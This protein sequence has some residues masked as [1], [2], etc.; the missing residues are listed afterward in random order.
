MRRPLTTIALAI[1]ATPATLPPPAIAQT[2]PDTP[3][4]APAA[5]QTATPRFADHLFGSLRYRYAGPSRG[6]RVT[7]VAGHRAH[8]STFYM[9]ATGGGVWKTTDRGHSWRNI[10]DGHFGT[11]SIGAIR[12]AESDFNVVYVS[13][14]SDG[15]RSNVI[16]G[17][18]V[19]KSADAGETWEHMGLERTGN[20]GA[21]LIHPGDPD[22]VYVAAIGSP[23][24]PNPERGVYRSSDGGASWEQVLFVSDSTGAVDLEFAPDDPN[25]VY[26][27]MWRAER[28]PWTIVSGGLEGGVYVSRDGGD[29]WAQATD[30]LPAGLRGKSDLAVSPADPDR[31]YVLIEAPADTGGVYRSDDRGATWHQV[32]D[33]QPIRNRP[34]YYTNL[35]AHPADADILWG[36]AEGHWMSI[37]GGRSWTRRPTPHSDNHDLWINP[38]DPDIMIQSN[39]GGANVTT[40]GGDTWSTQLN[41]PTAELYQ[42]D[43][44][45]GF[46]YRLHAG[47]QDN[48]TVSVPG[49]P[50]RW[51]PGGPRSAWEAHGGCETGPIVPKPGDPDIVYANCKGRFG[52]YNRRTGQEQQYYVG[53]ANLYGHNPRD[54]EYRFQRVA[55]VHVSPHD[56]N[57]V[58][59]GSQFVHV[60]TDGGRRWETISDDLTAFT[61][62]TQVV[63][64]TPI[65]LD[66]TGEEHFAALYEIQESVLEPGVI[67]AGANDGPVHVTRDG[68]AGW[69]DVTPP[70][71]GPHG[72]VQ[73]IEV[74]HHDPAKAYVAIL[75]YQLGDFAP[76]AYRTDD[77]GASWTRMTT[78]N[79]GVPGDHP[80]RVV[81]EDPE[82][83]GLL[84]LGT[85]FGV[86]VSFD[87]GGTWQSFQLNLP[88]TPVTD[89]K[90]VRGDLVLSTMGRGFWI[91][92]NLTPLHELGDSVAGASAH[93]YDVRDAYRLRYRRGFGRRDASRPSYPQAGAN[94]DY[95]LAQVPDVPLALD[96]VDAEGHLVRSFSSEEPGEYVV[97]AEPGMREWRLERVG[98]P[99]LPGGAGTHRFTWDLRH[100]GP[101]N[102]DPDRTGRGGPMVP[103]GRYTA[104]LSAGDW[105]ASRDFRVML[106]P[107]VAAEG[108]DEGLVRRQVGFALEVRDALSEAR[109]AAHR[110]AEARERGGGELAAEVEAVERELVTEPRRYSRPMLVDQLRY[111]Y[112]NLTRADQE[113]GEDAIRRYDRL[114]AALQGHVRALERLLGASAPAGGS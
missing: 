101:W 102:P 73:T 19:Y 20:S 24:A 57:K 67:W 80:V 16:I 43:V 58:Y 107:R 48:S 64:G 8:P 55:P 63:S 7:A 27:S 106:D 36:M 25:T 34:F 85:E 37:D 87:D 94:I 113:P 105:S 96:I 5:P 109:L 84:Y 93:L 103:P 90:V 114:N 75:R 23:F 17:D 14:G 79:N 66:V 70:G 18:G 97:P 41:Q 45:D 65:T 42:V 78:G 29:T 72:R 111:L 6:G 112:G 46:P 2:T 52:V 81:R 68:G 100:P 56:P 61:P 59:H 1:A 76:Y 98:T 31:V 49:L 86:F 71:T 12:V 54:L 44:S 40:D 92:D 22:F 9:G 88:A 39:D 10:S 77:Y 51:E 3:Q 95:T 110:I 104:R 47:Q 26:A 89:M 50:E 35:E 28:K 32:T 74:S 99:R 60:T 11:G 15:L 4:T 21:I 53:F 91:M 83:E 69:T 13:T 62:E 38:D 30:G 33:F 82:R 108:I